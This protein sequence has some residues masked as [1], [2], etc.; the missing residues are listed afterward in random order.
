M[1]NS[2][3]QLAVGPLPLT[4]NL[5]WHKYRRLAPLGRVHSGNIEHLRRVVLYV[6]KIRDYRIHIKSD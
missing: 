2:K 1:L 3:Y 6:F 4:L 5:V